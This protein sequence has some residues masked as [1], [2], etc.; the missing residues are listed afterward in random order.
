MLQLLNHHQIF[1]RAQLFYISTSRSF[2][3]C[4]FEVERNCQRIT[5]P[6]VCLNINNNTDKAENIFPSWFS[7]WIDSIRLEEGREIYG[8]EGGEIHR[9]NMAVCSL[10]FLQNREKIQFQAITAKRDLWLYRSHKKDKLIFS[11]AINLWFNSFRTSS[12]KNQRKKIQINNNLFK[13]K[14]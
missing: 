8:E 3:A 5:T 2:S 12:N 13:Q 10:Y 9:D 6:K 4:V 7:A 11:V 14:K 1:M